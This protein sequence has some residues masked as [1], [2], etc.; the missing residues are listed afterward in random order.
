[1]ITHVHFHSSQLWDY[2]EVWSARLLALYILLCSLHSLLSLS[3]LL[4]PPS[5][6][7]LPFSYLSLPSP[8]PHP[9]SSLSF[10]PPFPLLS[11]SPSSFSLSPSLPPLSF[12][13]PS[14]FSA[15]SN[16]SG[17][18][19]LKFL[20]YNNPP[21]RANPT[22]NLGTYMSTVTIYSNGPVVLVKYAAE[23]L[24]Q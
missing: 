24:K 23:V 13:P 4:S 6:F 19:R 5:P 1:M 20:Y 8:F 17:T 22:N 14:L 18:L 16:I 12:L 15:K 3:F 2:G 9:F 21:P 11:P 10:P 7:P